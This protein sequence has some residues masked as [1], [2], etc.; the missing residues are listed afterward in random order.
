MRHPRGG[1]VGVKN[2]LCVR[3]SDLGSCGITIGRDSSYHSKNGHFFL[4][5]SSFDVNLALL[6]N[7]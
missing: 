6:F 5:V 7:I 2:L 3:Q 1:N 4:T